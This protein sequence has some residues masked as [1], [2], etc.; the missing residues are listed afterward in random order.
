MPLAGALVYRGDAIPEWK[1]DLIVGVLGM[2]G[3]PHQLHRV[4]LAKDG[5]VAVAGHEA[6]FENQFGR[7][8]T[9][10]QGPDGWIYVTTSNCDSRGTCT[11]EKDKILRVRRR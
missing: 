10:V 8:R 5:S 2:S 11:A 7:L 6:Y 3:S 1:G 4:M 9:V